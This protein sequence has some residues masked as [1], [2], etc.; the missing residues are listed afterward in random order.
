MNG[1]HNVAYLRVNFVT[2]KSSRQLTGLNFD[3][4][5]IEEASVKDAKRPVLKEC[6]NFLR[7]GDILHVHS[8]DVLARNLF[9][10][11]DIVQ[12]LTSQG[13]QLK[14]HKENLTFTGA[15]NFSQNLQLQM[16]GAIAEF[17]RRLRRERQKE[18]IH[19]AKKAGKQ[20]GARKKL[21]PEQVAAIRK[22]IQQG[23][24]KKALAKEYGVS[25]QTLYSALVAE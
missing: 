9:D 12:K 20:I 18:G 23:E 13:I 6:L 5:F 21:S 1:T 15:D 11:Q 2:Q 14:F 10:L 17:E 16:L 25:R 19:A 3:K 22:R 24:A 4:V 8:F 7:E